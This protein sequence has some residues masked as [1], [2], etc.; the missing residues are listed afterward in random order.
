MN[1]Y[2]CHD[3]IVFPLGSNYYCLTCCLHPALSEVITS[4]NLNNE[5][6]YAHIYFYMANDYKIH[7]RF[8]LKD[9]NM[10]I[11]KSSLP[12][13]KSYEHILHINY[14]PNIKPFNVVEKIKLYL[15]FS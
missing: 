4:F 6:V 1:C 15:T 8:N 12:N 7:V 2:F 5:I 9:N 13:S 14:M 11:I 10:D 3:N